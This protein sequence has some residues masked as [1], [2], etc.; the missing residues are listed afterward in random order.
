M[1][2]ARTQDLCASRWKSNHEVSAV[3]EMFLSGATTARLPQIYRDVRFSG[4]EEVAN[5]T[6]VT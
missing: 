4:A 6:T 2:N 1:G 5:S 3:G